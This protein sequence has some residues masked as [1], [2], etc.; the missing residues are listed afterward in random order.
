M[1]PRAQLVREIS[2]FLR[3]N[4]GDVNVSDVL[5]TLAKSN[6]QEIRQG[7]AI[8]NSTLEDVFMKVVEK[9]DKTGHQ[10]HN[11]E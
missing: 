5:T 7:W 11:D 1:F 4:L 6:S 10:Q 8:S 9:Y 3:F 2:G